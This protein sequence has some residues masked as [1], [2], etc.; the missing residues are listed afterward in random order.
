MVRTG[1]HCTSYRISPGGRRTP[2][3][4]APQAPRPEY[5]VPEASHS[6]TGT[7]RART[8][9]PAWM[10]PVRLTTPKGISIA[11]REPSR[12]GDKMAAPDRDGGTSN[13]GR[14]PGHVGNCRPV[15]LPPTRTMACLR[16]LPPHRS[17]SPGRRRTSAAASFSLLPSPVACVDCTSG[18]LFCQLVHGAVQDTDLT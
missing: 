2:T 7:L 12:R 1:P 6:H 3:G 4:S 15:I 5:P 8:S 14:Y 9:N 18:R 13:P 16:L 10:P 17:R 11:P